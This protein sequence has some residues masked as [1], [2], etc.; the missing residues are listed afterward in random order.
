[1]VIY[2]FANNL[3]MDQ[4]NVT[5]NYRYNVTTING[6]E[7]LHSIYLSLDSANTS[8]M[9][10]IG[11]MVILV[12]ILAIFVLKLSTFLHGRQIISDD[13]E[14]DERNLTRTLSDPIMSGRNSA[15]NPDYGATNKPDPD[16]ISQVSEMDISHGGVTH[17]ST[18]NIDVRDA[19]T[20]Q[21]GQIADWPQ[22]H[23]FIK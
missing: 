6:Y 21:I 19:G 8:S 23:K 3:K 1:M 9:V 7:L 12:L 13:A 11:L 4:T 20:G 22:F 2:S 18:A 5:D 14:F 17:T 16:S 10:L 15:N